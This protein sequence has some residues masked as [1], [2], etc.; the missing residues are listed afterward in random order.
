MADDKQ[1]VTREELDVYCCID[2]LRAGVDGLVAVASG[3][4]WV[5]QSSD[6]GC[7]SGLPRAKFCPF[8]GAK[9]IPIKPDPD[10]GRQGWSWRTEKIQ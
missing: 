4:V 2:L 5:G 6:T 10:V 1:M 9:I 3:G 7:C 8:C